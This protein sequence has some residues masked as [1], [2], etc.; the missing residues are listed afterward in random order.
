M[1]EIVTKENL[2]SFFHTDCPHLPVIRKENLHADIG[3]LK[4]SDIMATHELLL[5]QYLIT[6]I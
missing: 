6:V 3:D 1:K 5:K 4:E 2:S